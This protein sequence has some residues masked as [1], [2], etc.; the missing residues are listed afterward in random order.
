V[1]LSGM[2]DVQVRK[3]KESW[4]NRTK[5]IQRKLEKNVY[6]FRIEYMQGNEANALILEYNQSTERESNGSVAYYFETVAEKSIKLPKEI[7]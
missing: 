2:S 1:K 4:G 6:T 5:S 3:I 7:L